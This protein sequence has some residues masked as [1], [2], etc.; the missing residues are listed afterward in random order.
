[1]KIR[2]IILS[3]LSS[4][5]SSC[6]QDEPLNREADIE[7]ITVE[8]YFV[9]RSISE[10]NNIELILADGAD[11]SEVTPIIRLTPG[12]TVEPESGTV[13]DF[14]DE[15]VVVYKV[16]SEDGRYTKEYNVKVSEIKLKY[17]FEYW[18]TAGTEKFSY[19][20]LS[21]ATWSNA[22]SGVILAIMMGAIN[23]DRFPTEEGSDD[24]VVAGEHSAILRTIQGG[25]VIGKYYAI[26]AGNLLRGDF[27]ANI[28]NPL[29]SLKLGRNHPKKMGKPILFKGYYKYK[30]GEKM[31]DKNGDE[32]VGKIDSF[33]MYAAIFRVTK[34]AAPNK[35]YLDG[36]TILTSERVVARAEWNTESADMIEK[37][38][39]NGFTEFAIP[40][41]YTGVLDYDTYDYRLTIVCSSSKDGNLYEGA[42]GSTLVVDELEVVCDSIE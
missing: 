36:E 21:D 41:K 42:V 3:I 10:D 30:P 16:T 29:K 19:P 12:A 35:E 32:M 27:F 38:A 28:S 22:N 9:D 5:F 4:L 25:T 8:D 13:Q 39:I 7:D 23:P 6:I 31:T 14:S 40:F 26:F 18:T 11:L 15:K 33:S 1:M 2:F 37:P 20:I 24:D 34:G 17:G